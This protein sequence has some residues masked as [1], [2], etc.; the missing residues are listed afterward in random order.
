MQVS[1]QRGRT[2]YVDLRHH[3]DYGNSKL[4]QKVIIVLLGESDLTY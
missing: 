2:V 4:E 1:K 3:L